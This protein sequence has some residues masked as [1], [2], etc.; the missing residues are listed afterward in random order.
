MNIIK[1]ILFIVI[2]ITNLP[3]ILILYAIYAYKNNINI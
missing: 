1:S 3:M 2:G